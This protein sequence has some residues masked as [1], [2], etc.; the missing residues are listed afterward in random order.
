MWVLNTLCLETA[1]QDPHQVPLA[2]RTAN[3]TDQLWPQWLDLAEAQI[4]SAH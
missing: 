4:V 1:A 3:T 2:L